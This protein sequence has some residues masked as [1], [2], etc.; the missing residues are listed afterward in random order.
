M[1]VKLKLVVDLSARISPV[2]FENAEKIGVLVLFDC[3]KRHVLL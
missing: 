3:G 2:D 1:E